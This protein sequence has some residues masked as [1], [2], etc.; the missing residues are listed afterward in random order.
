MTDALGDALAAVAARSAATYPLVFAAGVVTSIG[1]CAAPRYVAVAACAHA[2]RHPWRIVA[3]FAAGLI[4][5]YVVLGLAAGTAGALWKASTLVYVVLAAALAVSG[6]VTLWNANGKACAH[7]GEACAHGDE[8]CVHH[9]EEYTHHGEACVH[10]R[11][12]QNTSLGGVLLLGASSVL[13]VSP[14]CTPVVAG[15]AGLTFASGRS[16]DGAAL[17]AAFACGH[18]VPLIAA[19]ALGSRSSSL[20]RR[21]ARR[22]P[23]GAVAQAPAVVAGSL[24]LALAAYYGVLA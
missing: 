12:P 11:G 5:A 15:I 17:L 23:Y 1:P 19:G 13:V 2:A 9:G 18:A 8:A 4:G 21:I 10:D 20:V 16:F 7:G 6:A 22:F 24:V 3:A 14:C